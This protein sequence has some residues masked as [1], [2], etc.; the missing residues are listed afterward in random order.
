MNCAYAQ[1]VSLDD[2][3]RA[4]A[5][6][7][8]ELLESLGAGL[9]RFAYPLRPGILAHLAP[10][11]VARGLPAQALAAFDPTDDALDGVVGQARDL[12]ARLATGSGLSG[13][14]VEPPSTTMA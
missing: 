2:P 10:A 13:Q 4:H 11:L 3:G 7:Q 1:I 8:A 5:A 6:Q 12:G 14:I 9:K